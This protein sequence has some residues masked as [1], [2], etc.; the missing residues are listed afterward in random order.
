MRSPLE[1]ATVLV[2]GASSGLGRA[3][4]RELADQAGTLILVARNE[5]RL[6]DV[7]A[8]LH[9]T[10]PGLD[11]RVSPVDITNC[12]AVDRLLEEI[13]DEVGPVDVLV[14]SAGVVSTTLLEH[15]PLGEVEDM[16]GLNVTAMTY[17]I[18]RLVPGMVER[19]R[20]GILNVGSFLGLTVLPGFAAY[21]GTKHYVTGLTEALRAELAGTGVVVSYVAPGPMK[22]N[23][24]G[25][26]PNRT[27][28]EVPPILFISPEVAAR[29]AVRGFARGKALIVPGRRIRFYLGL[30]A[31]TPRLMRRFIWSRL[32]K[33]MRDGQ[34]A[35]AQASSGGSA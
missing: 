20:G 18:R 3:L 12:D 11:V 16:I 29:A 7:A 34:S 4:T 14:N 21:A 19:G 22:T 26:V 30:M 13:A 5:D 6:R 9:S 27:G 31:T 24:W 28:F 8:E 10:H 25:V 1:Q 32:S 23:F 17:L 33:G 2:T 15:A 35:T